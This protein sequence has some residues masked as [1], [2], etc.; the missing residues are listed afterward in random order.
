[1][2]E[3]MAGI[4]RKAGTSSTKKAPVS[5]HELGALVASLGEALVGPRGR[6]LR[7]L[8]WSSALRWSKDDVRR[9]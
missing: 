4:Q 6:A 3:T 8:G 2:F 9:R 7:T 5:D 1:V